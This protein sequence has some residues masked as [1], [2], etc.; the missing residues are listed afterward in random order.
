MLSSQLCTSTGAPQGTVLAPVLF[1]LYT[2][3]CRGTDITSVIKYSDDSAIEDLSNSDDVYFSAVRRFH[4]WCKQNFLDLNVLKIKMMLT[5][6]RKNP[7]PVPYLEID[8][9]IVER[10]D[11]YK[12]PG[13]IIDSSLAF[14]KN[15]GAIYRNCQPRPYYSHKLKNIGNDSKILQMY[16]KCCTESLLTVSFMCWY[17]NLCDRSKRV[18]SDLMDVC[19]KGVGAKQVGM[20][21]LYERRDLKKARQILNDESHVLARCYE[22]LPSGRRFRNF[23]V[24]ARAQRSSFPKP[25]HES[26]LSHAQSSF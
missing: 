22:F 16:C 19:N 10:V 6:S 21:E 23:K 11:E 13:T 5:D 14:N 12:Y 15:A 8:D 9:K 7:P 18:L 26:L 4:T 3:D 20:Q 1:T 24:K 25:E 17:G 2:N